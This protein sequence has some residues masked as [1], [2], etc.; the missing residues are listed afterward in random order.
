[1]LFLWIHHIYF[2]WFNK[3]IIENKG[4]SLFY[5]CF[6]YFPNKTVTNTCLVVYIISISVFD[7]L[8]PYFRYINGGILSCSFLRYISRRRKKVHT[9]SSGNLVIRNHISWH[10]KLQIINWIVFIPIRLTTNHFAKSHSPENRVKYFPI[11]VF[12][13][14]NV[15]YVM[16]Y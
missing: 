14:C 15:N 12:N 1:M 4:Y 10:I 9:Y 7:Y 6:L 5:R 2:Q 11:V 8:Y 3:I 13:L 16:W